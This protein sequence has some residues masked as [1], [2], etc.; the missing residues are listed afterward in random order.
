M[1]KGNPTVKYR[2]A[3]IYGRGAAFPIDML[4]YDSSYPNRESDSCKITDT[5]WYMGAK[6]DSGRPVPAPIELIATASGCP[7]DARWHSFGWCVTHVWN[8]VEWEPYNED[9]RNHRVIK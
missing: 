2:V 5:F 1:A 7:N 6:D 9:S 4:R 8:G 3:P